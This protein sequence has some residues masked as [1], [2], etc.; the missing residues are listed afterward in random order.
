MFLK[1]LIR[2]GDRRGSHLE[3]IKHNNASHHHSS[4][5]DG[6]VWAGTGVGVCSHESPLP[7][8]P[9]R[10]FTLRS[11]G[12]RSSLE[13]VS[14]NLPDLCIFFRGGGLAI[15]E[16]DAFVY[17]PPFSDRI[18]QSKE[19]HRALI[20]VL[21]LSDPRVLGIEGYRICFRN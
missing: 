2:A 7:A 16:D 20:H 9:S 17:R 10:I 5:R 8:L 13:F 3:C 6:E 15:S 1:Q 18:W 12:R 14:L 4:L 21:S 11:W 19:R